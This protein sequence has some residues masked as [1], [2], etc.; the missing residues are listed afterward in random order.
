MMRQNP[1]KALKRSHNL[2]EK[3]LREHKQKLRRQV[4]RK[5]F[6]CRRL[7]EARTYCQGSLRVSVNNHHV[8]NIERCMS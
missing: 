7:P 8:M 5:R 6:Q 4:E 1:L 3:L 2:H